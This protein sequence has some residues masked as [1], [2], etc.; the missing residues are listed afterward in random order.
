MIFFFVPSGL[1]GVGWLSV[2][3]RDL[4]HQGS[5]ALLSLLSFAVNLVG[6]IWIGVLSFGDCITLACS[7]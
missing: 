6:V 4:F 1:P 5:I 3:L 7:L 2:A